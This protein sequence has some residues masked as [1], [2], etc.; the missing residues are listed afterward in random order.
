MEL[1]L[2]NHLVVGYNGIKNQNIILLK[3]KIIFDSQDEEFDREFLAFVEFF[4]DFNR[5]FEIHK[6]WLF[7]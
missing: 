2:R 7:L 5:E 4:Y 6:I 3:K 1:Y